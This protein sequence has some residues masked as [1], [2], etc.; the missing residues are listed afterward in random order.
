MSLGGLLHA[1][2]HGAGVGVKAGADV[3][4]IEDQGIHVVQH[5]GLNP[6]RG[7]LIEAEN[8][9]TRS[10]IFCIRDIGAILHARQT[11]FGRKKRRHVDSSGQHEI[12]IPPSVAADAGLVRDETDPFA[13]QC[14]EIVFRQDVQAG[15][16][17]GL[18]FHLAVQ[19]GTND[20]LVVA[21]EFHARSRNP[22]RRGDDGSHAAA[23]RNDANGRDE[24][25][26][27]WSK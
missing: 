24:D 20:G 27:H 14:R 23:Q 21:G 12:D 10:R 9:Q 16:H 17:L 26:L 15:E 2:E 5:A 1:V 18:R 22:E 13:A 7:T 8:R 3:L 11:M 19:A 25:A 6:A 4:N